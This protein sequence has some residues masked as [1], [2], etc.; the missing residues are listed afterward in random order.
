MTICSV[1]SAAET[2]ITIGISVLSTKRVEVLGGVFEILD[3][4]EAV[5]VRAGAVH[6]G[7]LLRHRA[8]CLESGPG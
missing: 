6:D 3:D 2:S 5:A 1:A 8:G 4:A 7:A